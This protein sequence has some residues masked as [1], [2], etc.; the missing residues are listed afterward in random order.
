M[1]SENFLQICD[2]TL[3]HSSCNVCVF[4]SHLFGDSPSDQGDTCATFYSVPRG[5]HL[6]SVFSCLTRTNRGH[7][8]GGKQQGFFLLFFF[9]APPS[10]RGACLHFYR[11]KGSVIPIPR[12]QQSRTLS[13]HQA[14]HL[15]RFPLP[16]T[17][18]KT[19]RGYADTNETTGATTWTL[20][21]MNR[22]LT[23]KPR[24]LPKT[25]S[26]PP[27]KGGTFSL[28]TS[29]STRQ[30]QAQFN[31][32]CSSDDKRLPKKT[33]RIFDFEYSGDLCSKNTLILNHCSPP[34]QYTEHGLEVKARATPVRVEHNQPG[35]SLRGRLRRRSHHGLE[36]SRGESCY[37]W[38]PHKTR[39]RHHQR[40]NWQRAIRRCQ[41]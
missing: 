4:S 34:C 31:R 26:S 7:T 17:K 20:Q 19:T 30:R 38:G 22:I 12:E 6:F 28:T 35:D 36:F 18:E 21:M 24:L 40:T 32:C 14:F 37:L 8:A 3:F 27:A 33:E 9:F 10:S 1:S 5:L 25:S 2:K 13:T 41:R 11:E 16:I 15:D 39:V 23:T 29:S